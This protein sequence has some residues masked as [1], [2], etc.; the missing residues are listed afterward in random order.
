MQLVEKNDKTTKPTESDQVG[1]ALREVDRQPQQQ[2]QQ[3]ATEVGKM[4][5][6][7]KP[8]NLK[9]RLLASTLA[10]KPRQQLEQEPA[11]QA[12]ADNASEAAEKADDTKSIEADKD[13]STN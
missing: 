12:G 4:Q 6:T 9:S 7:G 8:L 10:P 3:S 13:S 11:E 1:E 2:Q 5:A